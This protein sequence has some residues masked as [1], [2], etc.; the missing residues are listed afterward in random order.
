MRKH[1]ELEIKIVN[2]L[3]SQGYPL[4]MIVA[5]AF[6]KAGISVSSSEYY[7]DPGSGEPREID[8][9]ASRR[10]LIGKHNLFD[11]SCQIE[12]KLSRDK[13]WIVFT[14]EERGIIRPSYSSVVC[15]KRYLEF[16]AEQSKKKKFAESIPSPK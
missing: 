8:V 2:W 12:C 6:E 10:Y 15:S 14:S 5:L 11:T 3:E 13:P 7:E 1:S 9:S 16:W 4:E